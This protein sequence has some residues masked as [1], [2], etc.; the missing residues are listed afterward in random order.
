VRPSLAAEENR[1]SIARAHDL[2]RIRFEQVL[3]NG[4][5]RSAAK[6]TAFLS[7]RLAGNP[8]PWRLFLLIGLR[9]P[10]F[11]KNSS[12]QQPLSTKP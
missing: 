8:T 3:V 11:M 9:S 12:G 1:A 7:R 5:Q 2:P 10:K 4:P 6:L